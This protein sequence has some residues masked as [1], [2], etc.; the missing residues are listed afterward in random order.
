MPWKEVT[1]ESE[2]REF[3][4]AVEGAVLSKRERRRF[5]ISPTT[6]YKWLRRAAAHGAQ[7]LRDASRA[8]LTSPTRTAADMEERVCALRREHPR[9]GGRKIHGVL[10]RSG[11]AGVPAPSTCTGI[12]RRT[13]L[14]DPPERAPHAWQRF[15]HAAPNL[16]CRWT[17]RP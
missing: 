3:V 2:R 16:L 8:P 9:W 14:L 4:H 17:S 6:G 13:G 1:V 7:D 15:E 5:Q 11:I 12:L 10:Q